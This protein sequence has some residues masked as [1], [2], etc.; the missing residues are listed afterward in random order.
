MFIRP[1][2]QFIINSMKNNPEDWNFLSNTCSNLEI[3]ITLWTS[4]GFL[5]IDTYPE[6]H[7]FNLIEKWIISRLKGKTNI[8][9]RYRRS[10]KINKVKNER[11]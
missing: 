7:A 8:V 10:L 3:D 1:H 5:F 11:S 4:N 9:G 2:A 6:T